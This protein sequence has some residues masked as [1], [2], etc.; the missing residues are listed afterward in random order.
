[1]LFKINRDFYEDIFFK[2]MCM[3]KHTTKL[4]SRNTYKIHQSD[5]Y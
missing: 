3:I 2:P 1:M 5:H 4:S